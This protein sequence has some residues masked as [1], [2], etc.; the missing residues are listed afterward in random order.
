[1]ATQAKKLKEGAGL[2]ALGDDS[3][4]D[5]SRPPMAHGES[6]DKAYVDQAIVMAVGGVQERLLT[7]LGQLAERLAAVERDMPSKAQ[8]AA[9][10]N[11]TRDKIAN[12]QTILAEARAMI[13]HVNALLEEGVPDGRARAM[14]ALIGEHFAATA[15][16]LMSH[17]QPRAKAIAAACGKLKPENTDA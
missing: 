3:R 10:I 13:A 2:S 9:D 1:M 7:Q 17:L 14:L 5:K 12:D 4:A 8:V 15:P 6:P 16:G 11:N